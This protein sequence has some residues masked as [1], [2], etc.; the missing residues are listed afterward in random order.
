MVFLVFYVPRPPP[1]NREIFLVKENHPQDKFR[2][3]PTV[4]EPYYIVVLYHPIP[5]QTCQDS[6]IG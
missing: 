1:K 5:Q 4:E 3:R 6:H 2:T